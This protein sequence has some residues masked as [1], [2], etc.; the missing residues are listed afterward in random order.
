MVTSK[1]RKNARRPSRFRGVRYC[2]KQQK[3]RAKIKINK[4]NYILGYFDVEADAGQAY[5]KAKWELERG[6]D[7]SIERSL[8]AGSDC[9][10][11]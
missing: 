9:Q 11:N 6:Q 8:Y 7:L 4:I 5:Q 10:D 1:P 3:W 2:H